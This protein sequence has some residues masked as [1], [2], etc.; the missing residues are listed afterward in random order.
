MP[1]VTKRV[2]SAREKVDK[3]RE[4]TTVEALSLVK[5]TAT[6][7]FNETV[8]VHLRTGLDGRH[9]DQQIRGSVVMP[10]GLGRTMR[11]AVFAEGEAASVATAA[12]PLLYSVSVPSLSLAFMSPLSNIVTPSL[13]SPWAFSRSSPRLRFFHGLPRSC[14]AYSRYQSIASDVRFWHLADMPFCTANV[15]FRG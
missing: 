1:K 9:A 11:V 10:H 7:K 3:F 5:E 6:A 2:E 13:V 14:Q 15:R 4:Y 8:E 12:P